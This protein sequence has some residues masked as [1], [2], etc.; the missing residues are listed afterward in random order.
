MNLVSGSTTVDVGTL[1]PL[2]VEEITWTVRGIEPGVGTIR[3][4]VDSDN[5]GTR[6]S[7]VELEVVPALAL[8]PALEPAAVNV[9]TQT[10]TTLRVNVS[11][12]ASYTATDVT[13]EITLPS[14]LTARQPTTVELGAMDPGENRSVAWTIDIHTTG[15]FEIGIDVTSTNAS[16]NSAVV[17][18][19]AVTEKVIV[20]DQ[21]HGQYY[22]AARMSA[23]IDFLEEYGM[24]I[25]I[26][27]G[28]ISETML[29]A[30]ALL[31][32]PNPKVEFTTDEIQAIKDFVN[33]GG[34]LLVTGD[35]YRYVFPEILNPITEDFGITWWKGDVYDDDDNLGAPYYP[36]IYT[37]ATNTIADILTRGV[38]S[39]YYS[40]TALNI[41]G[42]VSPIVLGNDDFPNATYALE[43]AEDGTILSVIGN[44]TEVVLVAAVELPNGGRVVASGSSALF[45]RTDFFEHNKPFITN[46]MSWLLR[47]LKLDVSVVVPAA[48]Y[49]NTCLLYTSPSPRDRG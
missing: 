3:V 11:N 49:A 48:A 23:F 2:A 21:A 29:D 8:Y 38:E 7:E 5:A 34:S 30:T 32:I 6:E 22:D 16:T 47:A 37:F 46:V 25:V 43:Q 39:I 20:F 13:V 45:G 36:I 17:T 33:E 35:W 15:I 28:T 41:T 10:W 24:P 44:G 12:V 9:Q 1:G 26:N 42:G 4:V 31:I 40:G 18:L 14:G 19:F 27:N